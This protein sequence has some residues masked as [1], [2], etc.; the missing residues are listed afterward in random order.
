MDSPEVFMEYTVREVTVK[1]FI[2]AR[3]RD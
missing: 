1:R 3:M 2:P